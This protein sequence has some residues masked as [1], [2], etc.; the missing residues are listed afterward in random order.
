MQFKKLKL[1]FLIIIKF[2]KKFS[3]LT[4][5]EFIEKIIFKKTRCRFLYVS[6]NFKFGYKRK[7]N[8]RTLKK[9]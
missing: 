5:K 1:D 2:D 6:R 9:I 4:A 8:V 7:G 3:S